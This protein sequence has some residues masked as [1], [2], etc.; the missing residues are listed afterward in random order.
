MNYAIF[1]AHRER[2]GRL[3]CERRQ[4]HSGS[5]T[6]TC[7]VARTN[8]FIAVNTPAGELSTI[9][10]ANAFDRVILAI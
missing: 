3:I 7:G 2:T 1:H 5:N 9:M 10:G 6:K 8:N 4:C